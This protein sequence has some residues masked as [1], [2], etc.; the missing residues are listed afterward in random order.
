M[1][2]FRAKRGIESVM[3]SFSELDSLA[4]STDSQDVTPSISADFTSSTSFDVTPSASFEL[5]PSPVGMAPN[6]PFAIAPSA[7]FELTPT[8]S[9]EITPSASFES[10]HSSEN[11]TKTTYPEI[12]QPQVSPGG[13]YLAGVEVV[14]DDDLDDMLAAMY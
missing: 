9:F 7:S 1:K 10:T 4:D 2:T 13:S 3:Q 8:P 12:A 5:T 11:I 14:A 6:P